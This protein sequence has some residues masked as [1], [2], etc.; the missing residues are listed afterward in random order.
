MQS[1]AET[2]SDMSSKSITAGNG[3][4]ANGKICKYH[5]WLKSVCI[6]FK[7]SLKKLGSSPLAVFECMPIIYLIGH[8]IPN[9]TNDLQ[10]QTALLLLMFIFGVAASFLGFVYSSF[11]D[12]SETESSYVKFPKVGVSIHYNILDL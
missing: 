10:P 9:T 8:N 4:A 11:P 7:L 12:M 6:V 1:D 5:D 3:S 2:I